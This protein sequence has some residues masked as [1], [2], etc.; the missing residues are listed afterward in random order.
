MLVVDPPQLA[1]LLLQRSQLLRHRR[2]RLRGQVRGHAPGHHEVEEVASS[3]D[4]GVGA[5]EVFLE[6]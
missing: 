5:Q 2:L 1:D 6:P 3:E 4:L